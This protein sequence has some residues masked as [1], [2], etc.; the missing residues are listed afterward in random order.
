[1]PIPQLR[2]Q[3][4]F[5][6]EHP[7][8]DMSPSETGHCYGGIDVCRLKVADSTRE[9]KLVVR[10]CLSK[11]TVLILV[12]F[13]RSQKWPGAILRPA[14]EHQDSSDRTESCGDGVPQLRSIGAVLV[15]LML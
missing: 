3:L 9:Y 2:F 7:S 4:D 8:C 1:M 13:G 12:L 10:T 5:G 15:R 6:H 14:R 11:R